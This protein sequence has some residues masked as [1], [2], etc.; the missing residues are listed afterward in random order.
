MTKRGLG[1]E[2]ARREAGGSR[3]A[4]AFLARGKG[5][6]RNGMTESGR[7]N[8]GNR[9][10]SGPGGGYRR[11]EEHM[12]DCMG[13]FRKLQHGADPG[14]KT[15]DDGRETRELEDLKI[16]I[17]KR[18]QKTEVFLPAPYLR[19]CCRLTETEY[20]LVL[21]AF[22]CETQEALCLEARK[23]YGLA[24]P[25]LQYALHL[26]SVAFPVD[27]SLIAALCGPGRPVWDILGLAEAPPRESSGALE[28]GGGILARPLLLNRFAF[29]FLLTG[30]FPGR[31]WC[32]YI[33]KT[34]YCTVRGLSAGRTTDRIGIPQ[35]HRQEYALLSRWL[36]GEE[37]GRILVNGR[38][39]SGKRTLLGEVLCREGRAGIRLKLSYLSKEGAAWE[40]MQKEIRLS[41]ILAEPVFILDFRDMGTGKPGEGNRGETEL[42]LDKVLGGLGE[43][44]MLFF[45]TD[46]GETLEA[47]GKYADARV[48]LKEYLSPKE[49]G[50]VLDAF[51]PPCLRRSWQDA[52][53]ARFRLDIGELLDKLKAIRFL[54][55]KWGVSLGE[56]PPW[57]EGVKEGCAGNPFGNIIENGYSMEDLVVPEDVEEQLERVLDISKAWAGRMGEERGGGKGLHILFHG[58]SGTGKT[59]AASVLASGL[60]LPLF[61]VDLSKVLDKYIGETEKHLD[62][63][64]RTAQQGSY[65]LFFDEADALFSK[66]MGIR[67]SRDKYANISTSYLLQRM[68]AYEGILILATNLMD[69]FDDAFLRRIRFVI[70]FRNLEEGDRARLWERLLADGAFA[71]DERTGPAADNDSSG[72]AG[73]GDMAVADDVSPTALAK[74]ARL[75]PARIHAAVQTA[76][77][78]ASACGGRCLTN[79]HLQAALDLEAGKDETFVSRIIPA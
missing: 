5:R 21:L 79:A 60:C 41:G 52:L 18:E 4:G 11:I 74:A 57:T 63:I 24:A 10:E 49:K 44:E 37:F 55:G 45:M 27:F 29:Y 66:R 36:R 38:K 69:H 15:G 16:G 48:D 76:K 75:S 25:T 40:E 77:M 43:Q 42:F 14:K 26:L 30:E 73:A 59:M 47:A 35:I 62:G 78:L 54:A 46:N 72:H 65:V 12:Q 53:M 8:A 2:K 23:R 71:R 56:E 64:F 28:G 17:F 39:G 70:K 1:P 32:E 58:A 50:L 61:K 51:L 9:E 7:M 67:D 20:W 19:D 13:F 6:G 31:E 3:T 33:W 68:E 34:D 22:C